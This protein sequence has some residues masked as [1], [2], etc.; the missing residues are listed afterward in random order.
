MINATGLSE[1]ELKW[2]ETRKSCYSPHAILLLSN[3]LQF[4]FAELMKIGNCIEDYKD[5]EH[6]KW[7]FDNLN[8]DTNIYG[9]MRIPNVD[10]FTEMDIEEVNLISSIN[11]STQL[12]I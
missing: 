3:A 4:S 12:W 1:F 5:E 8:L 2:L 7:V 11:G 6:V 10:Y 9:F